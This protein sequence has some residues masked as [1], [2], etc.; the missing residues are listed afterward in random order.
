[1]RKN[2][3]LGPTGQIELRAGWKE[4]ETSRRQFAA[5]FAGQ[6]VV[7]RIA[8]LMQIEDI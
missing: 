7:K 6:P 5:S 4:G 8:D 3:D 1:M 2:V